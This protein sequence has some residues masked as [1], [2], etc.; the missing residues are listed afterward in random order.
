[1]KR[2][3]QVSQKLSAAVAVSVFAASAFVLSACGGGDEFS[4][5]SDAEKKALSMAKEKYPDAKFLGYDFMAD[6]VLVDSKMCH[7]HKKNSDEAVHFYS[8]DG[9]VYEV[10]VVD[11]A[12]N[13]VFKRNLSEFQCVKL[14]GSKKGKQEIDFSNLKK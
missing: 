14:G 13:D 4:P 5:S 12:Q 10:I 9:D 3:N 1:M 8:K 11:L 6:K 7:F 2:F